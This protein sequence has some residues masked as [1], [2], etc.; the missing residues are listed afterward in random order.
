MG[1]LPWVG[2]AAACGNPGS[3]PD[4]GLLGDALP[5][6]AQGRADAGKPDAGPTDAP[7]SG[8]EPQILSAFFGANNVP[9][10]R[11]PGQAEC[12]ELTG[13]RRMDGMPV[14]FDREVFVDRVEARWFRVVRASGETRTPLCAT[15]L[16]ADE[17]NED[18]TVL[19]VGDLGEV[20]DP[21]VRVEVSGLPLE[22]FGPIDTYTG[23]VTEFVAGPSLVWVERMAEP[24][25]ERGEPGGCPA[26]TAQVVK[27]VFEG[28][29]TAP[30]GGPVAEPER[31]AMQVRYADGTEASPPALADLDDG[32][33]NL[34]LCLDRKQAAVELFIAA[35]TLTDPV[36]D[37]N[38]ATKAPIY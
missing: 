33:N 21:P 9:G 25:T 8:S 34:D 26:S 1:W 16:P 12:P 5:Q 38:P 11:Y 6:D 10:G 35:G 31:L 17:E 24:E 13:T 2:L 23:R 22:G 30:G 27:A 4:A 29:V 3:S 28:G 15:R 36:D 19:L 37:P 7:A 18:R 14:V 20:D 32:D